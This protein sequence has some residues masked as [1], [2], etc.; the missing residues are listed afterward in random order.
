MMCMPGTPA[1]PTWLQF[2]TGQAD[3]V[4]RRKQQKATDN[5]RGNAESNNDVY[6][7]RFLKTQRSNLQTNGLAAK[8]NYSRVTTS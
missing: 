3:R 8:R 6:S 4:G 7:G 2:R 1:M 5:N